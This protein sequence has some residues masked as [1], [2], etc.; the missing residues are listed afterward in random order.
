ME[1]YFLTNY[2]REHEI[3]YIRNRKKLS[4]RARRAWQ[5]RSEMASSLPFLAMTYRGGGNV[6]Y[7]MLPLITYQT[8]TD[9]GIEKISRSKSEENSWKDLNLHPCSANL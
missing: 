5:S 4:L 6:N 3:V 2:Y 7:N 1:S 9:W 8:S